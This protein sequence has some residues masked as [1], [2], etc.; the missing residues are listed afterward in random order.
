MASTAILMTS[1]RRRP[2][3]LFGNGTGSALTGYSG[4]RKPATWRVSL[5]ALDPGLRRDDV[6]AKPFAPGANGPGA[7]NE[8]PAMKAGF[9]SLTGSRPAPG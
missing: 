3:S 5:E 9:G 4:K 8:K 2:E 7:D 1:F 6:P